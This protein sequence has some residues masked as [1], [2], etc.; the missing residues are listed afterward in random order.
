M[1]LRRNIGPDPYRRGG[2]SEQSRLPHRLLEVLLVIFW[3][4]GYLQRPT[5]HA[6]LRPR[7]ETCQPISNVRVEAGFGL[8][9]VSHN[10]DSSFNLF[11]HAFD[12][13]PP[14]TRLI[15]GTVIFK[16]GELGLHQ[17]KK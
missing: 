10:I 16:A 12:Y 15:R 5:L 14:N 7:L 6:V 13:S 4:S 1:L 9:A 2:R 3:E 8:L 11:V 17:V